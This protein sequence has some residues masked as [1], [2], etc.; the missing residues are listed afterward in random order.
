MRLLLL[1]G[2]RQKAG[3]TQGI[4]VADPYVEPTACEEA[5]GIAARLLARF[6]IREK[7]QEPSKAVAVAKAAAEKRKKRAKAGPLCSDPEDV[8]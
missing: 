4:V 6:E 3:N 5:P 1:A 7:S 2:G 8:E